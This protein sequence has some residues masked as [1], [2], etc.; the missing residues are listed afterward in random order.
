MQEKRNAFGLHLI[1][2]AAHVGSQISSLDSWMGLDSKESHGGTAIRACRT[3]EL[4]ALGRGEVHGA[5]PNLS[6]F[7]P[8]LSNYT[9]PY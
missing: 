8:L 6:S 3:A 7:T 1:A 9:S 5:V 4:V 2:A